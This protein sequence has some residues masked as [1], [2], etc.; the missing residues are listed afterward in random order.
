MS[1][2]KRCSVDEELR[3]WTVKTRSAMQAEEEKW[4]SKGILGLALTEAVGR[5]RMEGVP[6][7]QMRARR[8]DETGTA[9]RRSEQG[10]GHTVYLKTG[11]NG[12]G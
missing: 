2:S 8:Q 4:P 3:C 1:R 11:G 12:E 5:C 7:S 9:T 10:R 6:A